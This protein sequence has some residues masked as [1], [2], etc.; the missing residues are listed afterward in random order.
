MTGWPPLAERVR[1][2]MG[3]KIRAALSVVDGWDWIILDPFRNATPEI[4]MLWWDWRRCGLWPD[5]WPAVRRVRRYLYVQ[6]YLYV[7]GP[8]QVVN[9]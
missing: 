9:D 1:A 8:W 3:Q 6:T 2:N 7:D 5:E 4:G